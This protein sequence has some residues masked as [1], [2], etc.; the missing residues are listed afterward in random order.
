MSICAGIGFILFAIIYVI[1]DVKKKTKWANLIGAAGTATLTCYM[2]P[3][4]I[5]PLKYFIGIRLPESFYQGGVG[6][7]YSFIFAIL[8]VLL[9]GWIEKKGFKLKL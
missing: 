5:N 3:Y 9:A 7:L 1:A 4:I 8:I 2:L 6:L